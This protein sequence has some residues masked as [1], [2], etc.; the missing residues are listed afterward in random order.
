[1][2]R[3]QIAALLALW[4]P[5]AALLAAEGAGGGSG[6]TGAV[7]KQVEGAGGAKTLLQQMWQKLRA[8]GPKLEAGREPARAATQVVGVRGAEATGAQV[9]PYWK[10]DKSSDPA[11]RQ[12]VAELNK[13][14]DLADS[15]APGAARALEEFLKNHP[16][17]A[18]K[19]NAQFALALA[20]STLGDKARGREAAEGFL[21]DNPAHP[22]VEDARRLAEELKK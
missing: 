2:K 22:L 20:Y 12:E 3:I 21:K 13:A 17:S 9:S 10:D 16:A 14:Q 18:L 8:Y 5:A 7:V 1:M 15:D 6:G 19:S 11:Y 4:I